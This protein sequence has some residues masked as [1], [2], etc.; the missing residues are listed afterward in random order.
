VRHLVS[1]AR[2]GRLRYRRTCAG[3]RFL[4]TT[5]NGENPNLNFPYRWGEAP[6]LVSRFVGSRLRRWMGPHPA[7]V[8]CVKSVVSELRSLTNLRLVVDF[9]GFGR[10]WLYPWCH[11]REPSPHHAGALQGD[12]KRWS[13][14]GQAPPARVATEA[15]DEMAAALSALVDHLFG[16]TAA[17][18]TGK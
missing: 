4:R 6:R 18:T 7:S 9:H 11:S 16:D 10:L 13:R 1:A 5:A 3:E 17:V 12:P 14:E 2:R 8:G 15:G